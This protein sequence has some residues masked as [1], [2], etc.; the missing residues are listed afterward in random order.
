MCVPRAIDRAS[1]PEEE[2]GV[3]AKAQKVRFGF[4]ESAKVP[5]DLIKEH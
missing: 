4:A 3:K 2:R 5:S 1:G